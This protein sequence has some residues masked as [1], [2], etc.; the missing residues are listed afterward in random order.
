M[1]K[2]LIS[3][4][5]AGTAL[6][7]AAPAAAQYYPQGQSYG[8]GTQPYGN[9]YGGGYGSNGYARGNWGEV[10]ALQARIDR[11]EWQINRLDRRDRIGDHRADRLRDEANRIEERLHRV[12]RNGLNPY[13][14]QDIS[15][16][17]NRLEQQVRYAASY[18]YG[19]YGN[20]YGG[21]NGGYQS[22]HQR[23]HEQ[24]DGDRDDGDRGD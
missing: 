24:H 14:V 13:E 15:Y 3:L 6:A 5:V 7:F 10:R 19:G 9:P 2:V 8:Y 16:R 4:A 1:R 12:A 21:Y 17:I 18:G 20:G 11:I 22:E 23:W